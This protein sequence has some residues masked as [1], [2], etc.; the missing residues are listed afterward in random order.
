[1]LLLTFVQGSGAVAMQ[2]F[3]APSS[4]PRG[5]TATVE[6]ANFYLD[7]QWNRGKV[8]LVSGEVLENFLLKFD[9]RNQRLEIKHGNEVSIC[10]ERLYTGFEW[11]DEHSGETV[12]YVK[13]EQFDEKGERLGNKLFKVVY[14]G[15][16]VQLL[17]RIDLEV[18][19]KSKTEL[20]PYE[21]ERQTVRRESY[22]M[23]EGE[24]LYC[25]HPRK[26]KRNYDHFGAFGKQVRDYV[27]VNELLFAEP[28]EL[29]EII[30]YYDSLL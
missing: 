3:L 18:V 20:S 11:K 26:E 7:D 21:P 29:L 10:H 25:L 13:R 24:E 6:K 14:S 2:H 1:M 9:L 12:R 27:A 28:E 19:K 8:F 16:E 30:R 17:M 22:F 15:E 23:S 5:T 4:A